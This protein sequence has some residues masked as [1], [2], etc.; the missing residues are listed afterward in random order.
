ML[1]FDFNTIF[2]EEYDN[3]NIP[4]HVFEFVKFTH[5]EAQ[6]GKHVLTSL[7]IVLQS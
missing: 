5:L 7:F 3:D 6:I 1:Q 2:N 4:S